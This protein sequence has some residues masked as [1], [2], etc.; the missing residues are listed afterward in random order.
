MAELEPVEDELA[1]GTRVGD[2]RYEVVHPISAGAMGSVYCARDGAN[3]THVAL[4]RLKD[5][6]QGARFAIEARLLS[7]LEH[8]RVVRVRDAFEDDSGSYLV[9]ELVEGPDLGDVLRDRGAPGLPAEEVVRHVREAG[10]ALRYV[11]EQQIVHRDV[12]PRNLIAG[13]EG[14]VLVDFGIARQ[15]DEG[16]A[17]TI[18]IGTPRFIAPEVLAGGRASPRSD[19]FSLAATA[20]TLLTGVPPVYGDDTPLA[21]SVPGVGED[22]EAALRMGLEFLPER[23]LA[24]VE[25]FARA[26]G[27][28]LGR[29]KGVSLVQSVQDRHATQLEKVVRTAAVMFDAAA[30]SIALVR[31]EGGLLYSAAWGAG[32]SEVVGMR[33]PAGQG[34]AGA[35]A[36]SGEAVVIPDCA[37]D[38]RF[39][40]QVA[41]RT[42]YVPNTM[43]VVPISDRGM[44]VGVLSLVDRRDGAGYGAD[45]IERAA[46]FAEL[47]LGALDP[48][49]TI[50]PPPDGTS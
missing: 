29:E 49:D 16:D 24:T 34:I 36:A 44:T 23:R 4:K 7:A 47:A 13:A 11:H 14:T 45:D 25:A 35:V 38:E 17:G 20:W 3:D 9:M 50:A 2:G 41:E 33:L 30:A 26:L 19:V 8:P 31:S 37:A 6:R 22:M 15:M 48:G 40:A 21:G 42:G 18:G 46:L 39:A 28:P 1:S 10:E 32:A 5:E 27:A 12:K 43:L